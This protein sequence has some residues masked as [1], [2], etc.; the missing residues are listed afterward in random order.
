MLSLTRRAKLA[1]MREVGPV[2]LR[3]DLLPAGLVEADLQSAHQIGR[4]DWAD[5]GTVQS[6]SLI[7]TISV[8][9]SVTNN[10]IRSNVDIDK[11]ILRLYE[12]V[13]GDH[14]EV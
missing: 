8:T 11:I 4:N 9:F 10:A 12:G 3:L 5:L 13:E 1:T 14:L 7:V 2:Q 6:E